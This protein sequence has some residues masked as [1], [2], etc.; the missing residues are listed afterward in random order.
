M[1]RTCVALLALV[2]A[3]PALFPP[4]ALSLPPRTDAVV[5]LHVQAHN[6]K[7]LD[8]CGLDAALPCSDFVTEWPLHTPADVYL[9]VARADG[10]LGLTSFTCGILYDSPGT[11][12]DGVGCDV[13]G[14]TSCC[15]F[16]SEDPRD[17]D[18]GYWWPRSGASA[19]LRWGAGTNCIHDESPQDGVRE[20]A[21]V[22]YVYAYSPD[23]FSVMQ[24]GGLSDW[25]SFRITTCDL[26][27]IDMDYPSAAGVVG[28]G[29]SGYN[30]CSGRGLT[31][32][33]LWRASASD[34]SS[35]V[36]VR[37]TAPVFGTA[38]D[39][40]SYHVY[41]TQIPALEF[42]VLDASVSGTE[43][44]LLLDGRLSGSTSYTVEVTGI[45]D[46]L[47]RQVTPGTSLRF[48]T[49]GGDAT[50]PTIEAVAG[51]ENTSRITV[52][53]SEN[54]IAGA[55]LAANYSVRPSSDPSSPV[56]VTTVTRFQNRVTLYLG[57]AL[58][59][60][61]P[62]TVAV[63][64]VQDA[65]GNPI[66]PGS[67]ASF[68]TGP[69]DVFPP[70]LTGASGEV[71]HNT[72]LLTFSEAVG[73]GADVPSNYSVHPTGDPDAPLPVSA[74]T[75]HHGQVTLTL[76]SVLAGST[77]YTAE[78]V[79]VQDLA[80][81]AVAANSTASFTTEAAD[82]TPPVLNSAIGVT[83]SDNVTV[84]FSEPVTG[85]ATTIS[86]YSVYPT[87]DSSAAFSIKAVIVAASQVTLRLSGSLAGATPYTVR[88]SNLTD[89]AGNVI[90]PNSTTE[91]TTD[92]Y[93]AGP[94]DQSQSVVAL[95][96][97][98]H[99][100]KTFSCGN[101]DQNLSCDRFVREWPDHSPADV[102]MV[103]CMA[104]P[105]F[106]V[107]GVSLGV[108]YSNTGTLADGVGCDVHG[109]VFCSDLEY[110]N[111]PDGNPEHEFPYSGGGNRLIWARTTNC[112]RQTVEPWG[113]QVVA[114]AFYVYAYGPDLFQV[115]M[116]R[117]LKTG[118][119]FK[120]IDCPGPYL[121]D[122]PWPDHAGIVGFGEDRAGYSPCTAMVPTVHTTWGRLKN[123]YR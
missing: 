94:G 6:T 99:N 113:V 30:P 93:G 54:V 58:R 83:G 53:F 70:E 63:S 56:A 51:S 117:N 3:F 28:F 38:G 23:H 69:G 34:G 60:S 11:Q 98:A 118:P 15:N 86:N 62:Y 24:K 64:N 97:Q 25:T 122:M 105:V 46:D 111:S 37:F 79:N 41:T 8:C 103:I 91:F 13:L 9:V 40:S 39:P 112:Q 108:R 45:E 32:L 73:A 42:E 95:H 88:V 7:G 33:E 120:I 100:S 52:T 81:N 90:V 12:A 123:Q 59:A 77:E 10:S 80:G 26:W 65:A 107:S 71:S 68:T 110:P 67:T 35:Q 85:G 43:V 4:A 75:H 2:I 76:G 18:Q 101:M 104:D 57:S 19:E 5:A 61:T 48:T 114:C 36:T 50:P 49:E 102:F 96:V 89:A 1:T 87:S 78:V 14:Y 27:T 21:G 29:S 115:D 84:R 119:E 66:T 109:Y 47:G 82:L 20:V 72:V 22:F 16:M 92:A 44:T 55:D 17:W 74:A 106:G 121:S 31:P 116:N